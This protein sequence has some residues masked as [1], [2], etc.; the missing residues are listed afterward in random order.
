MIAIL[1]RE[2]NCLRRQKHRKSVRVR[3]TTSSTSSASDKTSIR[4]GFGKHYLNI[5][6]S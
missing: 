2:M 5:I 1:E 4:K 3:C 6:F